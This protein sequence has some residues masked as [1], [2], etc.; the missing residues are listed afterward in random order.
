MDALALQDKVSRTMGVA[1]RKLGGVC[2]VYRPKNASRPVH[3][4]NRLVELFAAFEPQGRAGSGSARFQPLW[5][6]VFDASYTR[7]GDYIVGVDDTYFVATKPPAQ[8]VQCILTNRVVTISRPGFSS[9][10]G[11]NGLYASSGKTIIV[12]W[13]VALVEDGSA[14]KG[15]KVGTSSLGGWTVLLPLLPATLQLA[16]VVTDEAGGTYVVEAAEQNNS[17]WRLLVRQISA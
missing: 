3:D 9:Q 13:P 11:Y 15:T 4:G 2:V 16:D 1:A 7:S 14:S 10:G 5:R 6:G 17:G 8:P 12:G